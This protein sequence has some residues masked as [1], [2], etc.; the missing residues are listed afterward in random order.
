MCSLLSLCLALQLKAIFVVLNYLVSNKTLKTSFHA[1]KKYKLSFADRQIKFS[2]MRKEKMTK[3]EATFPSGLTHFFKSASKSFFQFWLPFPRTKDF[4]AC[5]RG[6][7][8]H[9]DK[10]RN[11]PCSKKFKWIFKRHNEETFYPLLNYVSVLLKLQ[12]VNVITWY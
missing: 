11:F 1:K 7:R 10:N 2:I 6:R 8:I 12:Y 5:F 9:L 3:N 4:S